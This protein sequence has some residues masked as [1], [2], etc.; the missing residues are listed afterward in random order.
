MDC[1]CPVVKPA[2][3]KSRFFSEGLIGDLVL[4]TDQTD[5][6][7]D[8]SDPS[9]PSAITRKKAR[10]RPPIMGCAVRLIGQQL[11][12]HVIRRLI[13]HVSSKKIVFLPDLTP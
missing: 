10:P 1:Q 7:D 3:T 8:P 12:D 2:A 11:P 9:D 6:V 5:Q 13:C 4:Q